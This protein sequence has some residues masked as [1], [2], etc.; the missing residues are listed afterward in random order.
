MNKETK[1]HSAKGHITILH[2]Q[3]RSRERKREERTKKLL[4]EEKEIGRDQ[5]TLYSSRHLGSRDQ[6]ILEP[7]QTRTGS[8]SFHIPG[9][10][11]LSNAPVNNTLSLDIYIYLF[12]GDMRLPIVST[13]CFVKFHILFR[14]LGVRKKGPWCLFDRG[15][16]GGQ[17]V[18]K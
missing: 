8:C 18:F 14:V 1:D 2:S 12:G 13:N 16:G 5:S 17:R 3:S 4:S 15:R 9:K 6:V 11:L 10:Y 7:F